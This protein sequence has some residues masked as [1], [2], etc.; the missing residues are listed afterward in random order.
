MMTRFAQRGGSAQSVVK[1]NAGLRLHSHAPK[2]QPEGCQ[3]EWPPEIGKL[4][5]KLQGFDPSNVR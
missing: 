5:L 2:N 3:D 1:G 4:V